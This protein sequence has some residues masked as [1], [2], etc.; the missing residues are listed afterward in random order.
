MLKRLFIFFTI[1]LIGAI[2][3]WNFKAN[4]KSNTQTQIQIPTPTPVIASPIEVK[5]IDFEIPNKKINFSYPQVSSGL[6]EEQM[7]KFNDFA[8][9]SAEIIYNTEKSELPEN[10]TGDTTVERA[11]TKIISAII[12]ITVMPEGAVHPVHFSSVINYSINQS[13][14]L[15]IQDIFEEKSDYLNKLSDLVKEKL[16]QGYKDEGNWDEGFQSFLDDGA[17]AD[18]KSFQKF[19]MGKDYLTFIFDPYQAGPYAY[20]TRLAKVSFEELRGLLKPDI[21]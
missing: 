8:S 12:S 17:K 9:Q 3:V 2:I 15:T 14:S 10:W 16:T 7:I 21:L 13:K 20:G 11:D 6:S 4:N 18:A 1:I 5:L 19:V